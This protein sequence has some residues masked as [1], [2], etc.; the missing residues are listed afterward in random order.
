M[1]HK[2]LNFK[3]NDTRQQQFLDSHLELNVGTRVRLL[4][5]HDPRIGLFSGA[6]GTIIS[7]LYFNNYIDTEITKGMPKYSEGCINPHCCSCD[8]A[9]KI[10]LQIPI[11]LVQF[12]EHFY[13]GKSYFN[14]STDNRVVPIFP[15]THR[16]KYENTYIY[17]ELKCL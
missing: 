12:D 9:A 7:F 1:K 16:I 14:N 2:L 11:V 8:I 10:N 4:R 5:N 6:T 13:K 15:I 17:I 3:Q